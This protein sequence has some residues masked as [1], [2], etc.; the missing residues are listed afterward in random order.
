MAQDLS[1][2]NSKCITLSVFPLSIIMHML[3]TKGSRMRCLRMCHFGERLFSV[4][5]TQNP[6]DA[7]KALCLSHN[8]LHLHWKGG[9]TPGRELLTGSSLP[10]GLIC[11]IAQTLFFQTFPFT[12]LLMVFFPFVSSDPSPLLSSYNKLRVRSL[13]LQS[14][15]CVDYS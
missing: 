12:F 13:S 9:P 8:C 7:I 11:I 2:C 14:Y 10:K 15:V 6:A 5:R 3:T 1:I 4:K